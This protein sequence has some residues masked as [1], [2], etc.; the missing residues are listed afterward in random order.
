MLV[1]LG[2]SRWRHSPCSSLPRPFPHR[3]RHFGL[4]EW[5]GPRRGPLTYTQKHWARSVLSYIFNSYACIGVHALYVCTFMVRS[6]VSHEDRGE[7]RGI[8]MCIRTTRLRLLT[9]TV[10]EYIL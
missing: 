8:Y 9:D 10:G 3:R 7:G 1:V 6:T 5:R 2:S 4:A